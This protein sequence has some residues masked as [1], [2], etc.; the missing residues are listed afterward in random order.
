MK[1]YWNN[2]FINEG[3]I[4]GEQP[5]KTVIDAKRLFAL[6]DVKTILV[7]GAGYGRNTKILSDSFQVDAIEISPEAILLA[8]Q[9]DDR[10]NFIEASIFE[11]RSNNKRYDAIYCY[12]LLHLFTKAERIRLIETCIQQLNE[13]GIYYFIC[14][15]NEDESFGVGKEI[16]E[17]T[18]EYKTGKIS[19]FF[20]EEDLIS[21]FSNTEIIQTGKVEEGFEY[22]NNAF[23]TYKLRYIYGKKKY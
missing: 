15:S 4:W 7:P 23:R 10:S 11:I 12:D 6:N 5:S 9:W 2:R 21:H 13:D 18:F 22:S 20:D 3:H 8:R 1:D 16:E 17:N 19:H 14:F